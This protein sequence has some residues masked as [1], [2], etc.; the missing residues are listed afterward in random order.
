MN[1]NYAIVM[2][3]QFHALMPRIL[4]RMYDKTL[5]RLYASALLVFLDVLEVFFPERGDKIAFARQVVEEAQPT[6]AGYY[7]S[8]AELFSRYWTRMLTTRTANVAAMQ[9]SIG[10][11]PSRE[12]VYATLHSVCGTH[13]QLRMTVELAGGVIDGYDDDTHTVMVSVPSLEVEMLD[14]WDGPPLQNDEMCAPAEAFSR[15]FTHYWTLV[16]AYN[17][18]HYYTPTAASVLSVMQI[19]VVMA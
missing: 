8:L 12:V 2:S 17:P 16:S 9:A 3:P 1:V 14:E 11:A 6:D 7:T 18:A 10:D 15:N 13:S 4:A 19:H 5:P